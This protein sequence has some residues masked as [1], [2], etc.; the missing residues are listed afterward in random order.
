MRF[1]GTLDTKTLG[2]AGFASQRT[3]ETDRVWDLSGTIGLDLTLVKIDGKSPIAADDR[4][5]VY[6]DGIE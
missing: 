1:Y 4:K 6:V 3:T 5:T 2:G